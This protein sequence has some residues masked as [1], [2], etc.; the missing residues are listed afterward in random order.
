MTTSSDQVP[1]LVG[2]D[3]L[4]VGRRQAWLF[5]TFAA[6]T[7]DRQEQTLWIDNPWRVEPRRVAGEAGLAELDR[8]VLLFVRSIA[9]R[10]GEL[11]IEFE[12]GPKLS[13]T[14]EPADRDS[15][16]WWFGPANT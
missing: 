16:G 1:D 10:A 2:W 12:D 8:L 15:D 5:V 13:V 6:P 9:Q 3:V 4:A 7:P 14:S 11:T